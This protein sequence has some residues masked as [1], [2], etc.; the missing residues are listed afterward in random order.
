[1]A[2]PITA[3]KWVQEI[4]P[5]ELWEVYGTGE[6]LDAQGN[7]I[8]LEQA[9]R[10]YDVYNKSVGPRWTGPPTIS[11]LEFPR[12]SPVEEEKDSLG[13]GG[14]PEIQSIDGYDY[15]VRRDKNGNII[16][17]AR[18]GPSMG[19]E[20][21]EPGTDWATQA[22]QAISNASMA[23][24]MS[25]RG[26]REWEQQSR[27]Q[28]FEQGRQE[29]MASATGPADWITRWQLVN[30]PNPYRRTQQDILSQRIE[31]LQGEVIPG[32]KPR[33]EQWVPTGG[34]E[35]PYSGEYGTKVI[36]TTAYATLPGGQQVPYATGSEAERVLASAQSELQSLSRE[37]QQLGSAEPI[38]PTAPPTPSWLSRLTEGQLR[39]G[40]PIR[41]NVEVRT[42]SLQQ[43]TA[44]PYSERQGF[45]GF[46][47]WAGGRPYSDI[48]SEME[49]MAPTP[50]NP[51]KWRTSRQMI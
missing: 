45:R 50:T 7:I 26:R 20:G 5:G 46:T 6:F 12:P 31:Q 11:P 22:Q 44:T 10:I 14:R 9:R 25:Q 42:P 24:V 30:T 36:P 16:E 39:A 35:F 19:G 28:G 15:E 47:E 4:I 49:M 41:K 13:L 27:E 38:R 40:E 32:V 34:T 2:E 1:M 43:W 23:A 37:L 33:T 3:K 29:A 17:Y 8:P 51:P 21:A 48:L 18:I